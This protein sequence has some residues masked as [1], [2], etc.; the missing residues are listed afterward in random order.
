MSEH[1]P[2]HQHNSNLCPIHKDNFD[3][4]SF[5]NRLSVYSDCVPLRN[6]LVF[7]PMNTRPNSEGSEAAAVAP[8]P[9]SLRAIG[10][11]RPSTAK[12][13]KPHRRPNQAIAMRARWA[14]PAYRAKQ[15]EPSYSAPLCVCSQLLYRGSYCVTVVV[16]EAGKLRFRGGAQE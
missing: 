4:P 8:R 5:L 3:V 1:G 6:R 7:N 16:G 2:S 13:R 12:Y 10:A 15:I 14:D 9:K 11:P